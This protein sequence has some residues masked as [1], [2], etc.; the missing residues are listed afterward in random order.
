MRRTNSIVFLV[1]LA[2]ALAGCHPRPI[3]DLVLADVA[4]RA[5]QKA[6]ADALAV[7]YYRK[8]ENNYLRAKKDFADGYFDSCRKH[9][10]DS[11]MLA[12]QAEFYA[13]MKQS[14][15]KDRPSDD[16]GIQPGSPPQGPPPGGPPGPP[17]GPPPG[18]GPE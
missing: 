8:A 14:Q 5:A 13:L 7:D 17:D 4:L 1:P 12:E 10:N 15:T 16:P 9:S 6:K 2:L 3:E 11:R 18:N